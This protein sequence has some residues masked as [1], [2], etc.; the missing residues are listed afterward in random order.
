[1]VLDG[2]PDWGVVAG[3]V[4]EAYLHVATA[5]LRAALLARVD[6]SRSSNPA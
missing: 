5:K 4:R 3:L 1:V 6:Q 2:K